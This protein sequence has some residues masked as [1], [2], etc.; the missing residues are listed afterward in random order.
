MPTILDTFFMVLAIEDT[1]A[2]KLLA[3]RFAF[4]VTLFTPPFFHS[5]KHDMTDISCP[6]SPLVMQCGMVED[7][8]YDSIEGSLDVNI[9]IVPT[10]HQL[11]D[12]P[13]DNLRG[14]PTRWFIEDV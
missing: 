1:L 14:Y 6:I 8:I 10:F 7:P 13:L 2:R 9:L 4:S 11:W 12:R 3:E 5:S